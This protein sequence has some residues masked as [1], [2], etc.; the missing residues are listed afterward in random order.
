MKTKYDDLI[1]LYLDNRMT[2]EEKSKFENEL[3]SS[4]ELYER[5]NRIKSNLL[6]I[7]S[8]SSPAVEAD[9]LNN[10]L[11]LFRQKLEHKRSKMKLFPG[12]AAFA[13]GLGAVI[14]LLFVFVFN[15]DV[16]N[17][18]VNDLNNLNYSEADEVFSSYLFPD[19]ISSFTYDSGSEL[20]EKIDSIFAEQYLLADAAGGYLEYHSVINSISDEEAENIYI[21]LL[22]KDIMNG[23][24]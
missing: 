20:S 7:N 17:N 11:P 3:K 18:N 24:L 22:N 6:D 19:D 14:L 9:Y 5:Y 4:P 2:G 13:S 23:E 10:I 1:I 16:D 15:S 21:Q 8:G 12:Y